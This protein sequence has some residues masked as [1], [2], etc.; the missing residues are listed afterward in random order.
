MLNFLCKQLSQSS[1]EIALTTYSEL[2]YS[3][4]LDPDFNGI[5]C[6]PFGGLGDPRANVPM[7]A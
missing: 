4:S 7:F 2:E 6:A 1:N 5:F 3:Q